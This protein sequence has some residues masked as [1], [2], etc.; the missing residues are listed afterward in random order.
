[1]FIDT[2]IMEETLEKPNRK[3]MTTVLLSSVRY[4]SHEQLLALARLYLEMRYLT[5]ND[6]ELTKL[7]FDWKKRFK[8][9]SIF[10][11]A[12]MWFSLLEL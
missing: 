3:T 6:K 11:R 7:Y 2:F 1:M 4:L 8:G 5:L 9:R 10:P 12:L